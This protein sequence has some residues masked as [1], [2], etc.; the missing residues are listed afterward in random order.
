MVE[1]IFQEFYKVNVAISTNKDLKSLTI[2]SNEAKKFIEHFKLLKSI[3]KAFQLTY[4]GFPVIQNFFLG[5]NNAKKTEMSYGIILEVGNE[6]ML[7]STDS[8]K[9]VMAKLNKQFNNLIILIT[10][11]NEFSFYKL[12]DAIIPKLTFTTY[13][14]YDL[15]AEV[16]I[17]GSVWDSIFPKHHCILTRT[18]SYSIPK[19]YSENSIFK[20]KRNVLKKKATYEENT[21]ELLEGLNNESC[22]LNDIF[23]YDSMLNSDTQ[24]HKPIFKKKEGKFIF[25]K[26]NP[27]RSN[28]FDFGTPAVSFSREDYVT[29]YLDNKKEFH[30]DFILMPNKWGDFEYDLKEAAFDILHTI[31]IRR[32]SLFRHDFTSRLFNILLPPI[33]LNNTIDKS[34][35]L[36]IF[37]C[38]LLNKFP[39]NLIFRSTINI[40][41]IVCCVKEN[42][43][44]LFSNK[45]SLEKIYQI[46]G[47]LLASFH[48]FNA[49]L[50]NYNS[51]GP[52][53]KYLQIPDN[54]TIPETLHEINKGVL[55]KLLQLDEKSNKKI[56]YDTVQNILYSQTRISNLASLFLLVDW[57]SQKGYSQPW[58][59]W[60]AN[61]DYIFEKILFRTI[62]Y[63]DFMNPKKGNTSLFA[64]NMK[65][66]NIGNT[67]GADMTG[68]TLFNP[69]EDM[70]IV[71]FPSDLENYPNLSLIRWMAW[72]YYIDSSLS[73]L[74]VLI[75]K[76][77]VVLSQR[78]DLN[79]IIETLNQMVD[80]FVELY[81]L[82]LVNLF[83]R[84]EYEKIRNILGIDNDYIQLITQFNSSKEDSSLREQRLMNKLIVGLTVAT[85]TISVITMIATIEKWNTFKYITLTLLISI[86]LVWMGYILF[87]PIRKLFDSNIIK[88][89]K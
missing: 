64:L 81:D 88:T 77:H 78:T 42:N 62:S 5:D 31:A 19:Q 53:K 44:H 24:A 1:F 39:N 46:K 23:S 6:I 76:F 63:K 71:I 41:Y 20:C 85:A 55:K 59:K 18:I 75:D 3:Q 28:I 57:E 47:E 86:I 11:F 74:K 65:S 45:Q 83:Y 43:G 33:L 7:I 49:N 15:N 73:S 56:V 16:K 61:Q 36:V 13:S 27:K 4:S 29:T 84:K 37:P 26:Y 58:E 22:K 87:D 89:K 17:T 70:K 8:V 40:T 72:H 35:F 21:I 66:L 10:D 14:L 50:I 79:F 30:R 67:W 48:C 34:E 69:R 32:T 12:Q 54:T 68:M 82:D 9:D 25:T 38:L 2:D 80:E 51:N 60:V 52:L